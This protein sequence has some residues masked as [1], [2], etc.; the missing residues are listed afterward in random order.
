MVFECVD[1]ASDIFSVLEVGGEAFVF[2]DGGGIFEGFLVV[3]AF[4]IELRLVRPSRLQPGEPPRIVAVEVVVFLRRRKEDLKKGVLADD[5]PDGAVQEVAH[6]L[7]DGDTAD[8][9]CPGGPEELAQ[10]GDVVSKGMP[11]LLEDEYLPAFQVFGILGEIDK[12]GAEKVVRVSPCIDIGDVFHARGLV[13][14]E[15]PVSLKV[16]GEIGDVSVDGRE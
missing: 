2:K 11:T 8:A 12:Q 14:K 13:G 3:G 10:I 16:E 1:K 4:E 9:P 7:G 15:F 5:P 6:R